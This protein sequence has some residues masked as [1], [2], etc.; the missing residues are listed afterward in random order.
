VLRGAL[1][2]ALAGA[3]AEELMEV[4]AGALP[5][6]CAEAER[7][8]G[9]QAPQAAAPPDAAPPPAAPPA[10]APPAATA[11]RSARVCA[12]VP[13]CPPAGGGVPGGGSGGSFDECQVTLL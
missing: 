8:Q 11:G 12:T 5:P 4:P 6:Q 3:R 13:L 1:E 10:A 7:L 9:T 2:A